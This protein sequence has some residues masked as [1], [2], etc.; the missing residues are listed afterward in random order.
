MVGNITI[1][2]TPHPQ[3]MQLHLPLLNSPLACMVQFESCAIQAATRTPVARLSTYLEL[4]FV[5]VAVLV[6][7]EGLV[8]LCSWRYWL[9]GHM[10]RAPEVE[11]AAAVA[12]MKLLSVLRSVVAA[13]AVVIVCKIPENQHSVTFLTRCFI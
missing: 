8:S 2:T 12:A 7:F 4:P 3:A 9:S 6:A 1:G 5:V 11:S 10:F 13:V